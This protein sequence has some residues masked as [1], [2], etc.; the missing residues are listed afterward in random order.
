[1]KKKTLWVLV[2]CLM[3]LSLI[4]ASCAP[5]VTE[6]EE[7]EV[8]APPT[9][10]KYGGKLYY[11]WWTQMPKFGYPLN[12][13][14]PAATFTAF[15]YEALIART[16]ELGVYEPE[17]ATSWD[18]APD[19]SSYTFHLR[20]GVKF[21]DGT[22][23]N[24]QAAKW[25]LDKVK[26]SKKPFLKTV[27][28]FEVKDDY[29]LIAH[30]NTWD[31][32]TID[33][34]AQTV[35]QMISPT[36]YEKNGEEWIDTHPV[37]TGPYMFDEWV[38]GQYI[39]YVK[40]PDYW[41]EGLPYIDEIDLLNIKDPTTAKLAFLAGEVDNLREIDVDMAVELM[42][43]GKAVTERTGSGL[44]CF[45]WDSTSPNSIWSDQR[46]RE[47]FEYAINKEKIAEALGK[48]YVDASY[49]TIFSAS[50]IVGDAGTTPRKY[51]PEK[52][53]QLMADAGYPDGVKFKVVAF[54]K[55]MS[56]MLI[57][58][59][60]DL[61]KVGMDMEIEV[62]PEPQFQEIRFIASENSDLRWDRN[63]GGSVA[64]LPFVKEELISDS[65]YYPGMKRPD[66]FDEGVKKMLQETDF[67]KMKAMIRELEQMYYGAATFVPVFRI[68]Q[69]E[70]ISTRIHSDVSPIWEAAGGGDLGRVKYIWLD[71]K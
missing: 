16:D 29:T 49:E 7:K 20:K 35:S 19:K 33:D 70:A 31:A 4:L 47:A 42:A 68:H 12:W 24:A 23:F 11:S 43:T 18:L 46:M 53:K 61:K 55:F 56:P 2:S 21:H 62:I 69:I 40:N 54:P 5:A 66:G 50:D 45:W 22:P 57:A 67:T 71:P 32:L 34:F 39:R 44:F 25:W 65:L 6:E 3:V 14:G 58:V 38:Q 17:L 63:R 28:E 37:G 48:G 15:A 27:D 26:D 59:Q 13:R 64:T 1:M 41:M 52:A 10:G 36:A 9:E 60:A 30:L 51:D 8:V